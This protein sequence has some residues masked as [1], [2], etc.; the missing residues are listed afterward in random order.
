MTV[1][2]R[3]QKTASRLLKKYA[4][5]NIV[6]LAPAA[7]ANPWEPSTGYTAYPINAVASGVSQK[8]LNN[9]I[10]TSDIEITCAVSSAGWEDSMV[11]LD[12]LTWSDEGVA[13]EFSNSGRISIDGLEKQVLMV[14]KIPAAGTPVCYKI[15]AKG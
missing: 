10:T 2:S 8:Y 13:L 3:M 9:L 7:A 12:N 15:F 6:Y 5:G 4:Q 1:Y 11:W 14:R